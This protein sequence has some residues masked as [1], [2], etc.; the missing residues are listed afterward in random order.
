[1]CVYVVKSILFLYTLIKYSSLSSSSCS[2]ATSHD[3]VP[4]ARIPVSPVELSRE[5]QSHSTSSSWP[6]PSSASGH[7]ILFLFLLFFFF[8]FRVASVYKR[9]CTSHGVNRWPYRKVTSARLVNRLA[10]RSP[11]WFTDQ[12]P[13][14]RADC[15]RRIQHPA[16]ASRVPS[17]RDRTAPQSAACDSGTL[18]PN[19]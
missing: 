13:S 10:L 3:D 15:G 2:P 9:V 11:C 7:S 6:P 19:A 12:T 8:G 17:R 14:I 18:P 1:M 16:I 4:S 5:L